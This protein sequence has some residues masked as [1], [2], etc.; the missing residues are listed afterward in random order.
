MF[1][2]PT[3]VEWLLEQAVV[4]PVPA[5]MIE[6]SNN[7]PRRCQVVMLCSIV[8]VMVESPKFFE[9][10]MPQVKSS[11]ARVLHCSYKGHYPLSMPQPQCDGINKPSG[12]NLKTEAQSGDR[13][14]SQRVGE[15]GNG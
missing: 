11:S 13:A 1:A 10:L 5:K 9:R 12:S 14:R 4:I 2:P 6:V 15:P 3:K 7:R 8:I